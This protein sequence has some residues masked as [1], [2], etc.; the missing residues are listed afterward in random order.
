MYSSLKSSTSHLIPK[1]KLFARERGGRKRER[2]R[3][4]RGQ[5][6]QGETDRQTETDIQT[7]RGTE[8]GKQTTER[9]R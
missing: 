6:E 1:C 7:Q 2:E 3:G 4:E 8:T 9:Q 5:R